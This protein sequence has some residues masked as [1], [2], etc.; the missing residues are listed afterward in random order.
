[1]NIEMNVEAER[2][3]VVARAHDWLGTPFHAGARVRGAGVDCAQLL[4]AVF[5]EAGLIEP[6]DPGHYPPDWFLH[7]DGEPLL[8]WVERYGMR[9]ST[10]PAPGDVALFRYGRAVS[11]GA[12][13]V[14]PELLIH[15]YR[16][17]GVVRE[18][19]APGQ[20]ITPRLVGCWTLRRWVEV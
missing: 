14:G 18:S 10:T 9:T 12:I 19:F 7:Q 6:V 4:I 16:G 17:L 3:A 5:A 20:A 11:H 8:A 1:M 15:S 13:V 2:A